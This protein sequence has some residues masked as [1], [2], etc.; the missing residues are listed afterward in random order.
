MKRIILI[1]SL[2]AVCLSGLFAKADTYIYDYWSE[3]EK[4]PDV[5]RV[6]SVLYA[7]DFK[8]DTPL[9]SPASLFCLGNIV[10]LVD[11]DNN[12]I[13]ELNYNDDTH[14]LEE[15]RQDDSSRR[16]FCFR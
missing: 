14:S 11:K 3:I 4:S 7:D 9:K 10:Y 6:S 5:Y 16:R 8:L 2:L 12:R 15:E 1:L 13:L